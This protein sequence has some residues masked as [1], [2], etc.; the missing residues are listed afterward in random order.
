MLNYL[1]VQRR[2][3]FFFLIADAVT[4]GPLITKSSVLKL[5]GQW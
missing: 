3:L 4:C 1:I 2:L 5:Q